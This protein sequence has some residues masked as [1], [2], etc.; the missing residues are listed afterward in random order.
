[1]IAFKHKH[2]FQWGGP[3]GAPHFVDVGEET[4]NVSAS[5]IA[6]LC[7][8]CKRG[9]EQALKRDVIA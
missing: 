5:E 3:C 2:T 9:E 4:G 6:I 8:R 7:H 1:M